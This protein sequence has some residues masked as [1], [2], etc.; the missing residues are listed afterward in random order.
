MTAAN[1]AGA[2]ISTAFALASADAARGAPRSPFAGGIRRPLRR[3]ARRLWIGA[4]LYARGL[5]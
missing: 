1:K 3:A 5:A 4:V 2:A